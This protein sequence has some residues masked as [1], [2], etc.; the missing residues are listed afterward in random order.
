MTPIEVL[1]ELRRVQEKY[2]NNITH[3]GQIIISDLAKD[4][5]DAIDQLLRTESMNWEKAPGFVAKKSNA[6]SST[7]KGRIFD[8]EFCTNSNP[9]IKEA[10]FYSGY[11]AKTVPTFPYKIIACDFDGTLAI[12]NYPS[13]G[14]AIWHTISR[15]KKEQDKGS[16]IILW[17]NRTG[18]RLDDAIAWC[19]T[20]GIYFDAINDNLPEVIEQFGVN[21]RKVFA[22]EYW[23]DRAHN[24]KGELNNEQTN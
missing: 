22:D 13:I 8:E 1:R 9:C 2:K 3:T 18:S 15:L 7:C 17:T 5:A 14:A 16:K 6:Q 4:A 20:A 10:G 21:C 24:M 11:V 19:Q 12:D 23:D